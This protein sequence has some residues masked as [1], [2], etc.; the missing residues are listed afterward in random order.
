MINHVTEALHH[1]HS[2]G[3][4]HN[5]LKADNVVL[6]NRED[7]CNAVIIDFGK[8][9]KIDAPKNRKKLSKAEQKLFQQ[10]Y[11][12]IAPEIVSSTGDQTTAS[13]MY[14]LAKILFL[15]KLV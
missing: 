12:H 9:R 14:S 13:D 3:F 10:S 2:K 15:T 8:S 4:L 1:I 11:P 6:E 7:G 5:D